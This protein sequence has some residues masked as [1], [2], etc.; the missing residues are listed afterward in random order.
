MTHPHP[1]PLGKHSRP[2]RNS[3]T[4]ELA[5]SRWTNQVCWLFTMPALIS[6]RDRPDQE[7]TQRFA[8]VEIGGISCIVLLRPLLA[9]C[10]PGEGTRGTGVPSKKL[11]RRRGSGGGV[12]V[13]P[14]RR[15]QSKAARNLLVLR[16]AGNEETYRVE[17]TCSQVSP[18]AA[19]AAVTGERH[20]R[21]HKVKCCPVTPGR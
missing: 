6:S 17:H 7:A 20:R 1:R 12:G 13:S 5:L 16:S 19:A 10:T 15:G 2:S 8:L 9:A 21:R 3:A 18:A 4:P 14:R 11:R